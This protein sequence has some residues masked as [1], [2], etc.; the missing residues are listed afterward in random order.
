MEVGTIKLED[1]IN[2]GFSGVMVRGSGLL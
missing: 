2:Y 1:A